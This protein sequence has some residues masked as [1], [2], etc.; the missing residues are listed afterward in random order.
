M[1][2]GSF[3]DVC[4]RRMSRRLNSSASCRKF[5]MGERD[6]GDKAKLEAMPP[7]VSQY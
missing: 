3:K 1:R 5:E 7:G 4:F 2:N 6:T